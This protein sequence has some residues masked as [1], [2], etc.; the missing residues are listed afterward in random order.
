MHYVSIST[1][2]H[3]KEVGENV[4]LC[5]YAHYVMEEVCVKPYKER[6]VSYHLANWDAKGRLAMVQEPN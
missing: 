3:H 6:H 2:T 5:V 1:D 4:A